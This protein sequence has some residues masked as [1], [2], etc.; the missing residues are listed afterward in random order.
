MFHA[1]DGSLEMT[2]NSEA[3]QGGGRMGFD[4]LLKVECEEKLGANWTG[5]EGGRI[6]WAGRRYVPVAEEREQHLTVR[7]RERDGHSCYSRKTKS[8][9]RKRWSP[10]RIMGKR[11][12]GKGSRY[13]HGSPRRSIS[14]DCLRRLPLR[15]SRSLAPASGE[16]M[17]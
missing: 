5:K 7:R 12:R 1:Q 15:R 4:G 17:E 9:Q 13:R 11:R 3:M 8:E 10:W 6:E 16:T 2:V 14:P